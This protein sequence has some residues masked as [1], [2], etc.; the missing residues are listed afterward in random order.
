MRGLEKEG[1]TFDV[2]NTV[3]GAILNWKWIVEGGGDT[4]LMIGALCWV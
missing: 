4:C 2:S 1:E 3:L